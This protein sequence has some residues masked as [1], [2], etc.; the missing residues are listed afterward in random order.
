MNDILNNLFSTQL[1]ATMSL[2][3]SL[4]MVLSALVLGVLIALV[5]MFI[6]RRSG[7][8]HEMILTLTFLPAIVCAI[9]V[10]VGNNIVY[11][12]SMGG[13]FTLVRYRSQQTTQQDLTFTLFAVAAGAAC[14]IGFIA[15]GFL[16]IAV[17]GVA[18]VLFDVL[19]FGQG[20]TATLRLRIT[21]PEDLNT[22]GAFDDVLKKYT[23]HYQLLELR[24]SNFGSLYD[25]IYLVRLAP[26]TNRKD[27]LDGIRTK[28][29]NLNVSLTLYEIEK[30]K[31]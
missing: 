22:E 16:F 13:I 17:I 28:N 31:K 7:F 23:K 9:I 11:A 29:G 30:K 21:V 24:T 26:G 4:L 3:T 1:G 12:L 8:K 27:F 20:R 19:K 6:N 14:G 5:Y 2:Q 15:Y 18:I 25:L 10:L